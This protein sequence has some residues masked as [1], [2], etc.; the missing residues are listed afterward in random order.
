[1]T[2]NDLLLIAV[3]MMISLMPLA[4]NSSSEKK[5]A[6]VKVDG[7]IVRELDLTA[8]EIFTVETSRGKNIVTVCGEFFR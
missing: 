3:L 4:M 5:I 6:V 2:R 7:V 1:M 8:E